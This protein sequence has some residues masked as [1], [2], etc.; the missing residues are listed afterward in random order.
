MSTPILLVREWVRS[1][2]EF[3]Q[4]TFCAF[5]A[6]DVPDGIGSVVGPDAASFPPG[7]RIIDP[8]IHASG[9]EAQRV[10]HAHH[11]KFLAVR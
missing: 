3:H 2:L 11:D 8:A 4:I 7:T 5:P 6:L 1:D 10:W 9:V